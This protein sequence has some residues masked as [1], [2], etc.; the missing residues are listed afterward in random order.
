VGIGQTL[1][2]LV[3]RLTFIE[4]RPEPLDGTEKVDAAN[5]RHEDALCAV[6]VVDVRDLERHGCEPFDTLVNVQLRL[7]DLEERL[8]LTLRT[9]V[10]RCRWQTAKNPEAPLYRIGVVMVKLPVDRVVLLVQVCRSDG[11]RLVHLGFLSGSLQKKS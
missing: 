7:V 10:T 4:R 6:P 8:S 11:G 1:V 9:R 2:S 5:E 3:E